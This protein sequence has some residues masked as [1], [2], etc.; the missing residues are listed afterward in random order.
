MRRDRTG[1][2]LA[3]S[4]PLL[5]FRSSLRSHCCLSSR[6]PNQIDDLPVVLV[7]A[8]QAAQFKARPSGC[9]VA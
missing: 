3:I 6:A 2:S 7:R 9:N 4:K 8:V 5:Q 1:P